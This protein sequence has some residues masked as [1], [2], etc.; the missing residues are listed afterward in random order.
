MNL[1]AIE[2]TGANASVAIINENRKIWEEHCDETL[3]HLRLLVPMIERLLAKCGLDLKEIGGIAVSE[4]PGSFTGIRIGMS[5]AKALAQTLNLNIVCVPTLKAF[6]YSTVD[7]KR[8]LCPIFDARRS[9]IYTGAYLWEEQ[10]GCTQLVPDGAYA[11]EEFLERIKTAMRKTEKNEILFFGD[12]ISV[13]K[14]KI[15]EWVRMQNTASATS[16]LHVSF[17]PEELRYQRASSVAALGYKLWEQGKAQ[18]LFQVKPVYLRQAE[19][20]RKLDEAKRRLVHE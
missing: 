14:D 6:A 13:Y 3:N 2:T 20:Q 7:E 11:L 12:G 16:R 8:V 19:A 10:G 1:L 15:E 4:G 17:A 5:T 18:N 9:Q